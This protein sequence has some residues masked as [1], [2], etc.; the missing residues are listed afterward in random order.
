MSNTLREYRA[1][2]IGGDSASLWVTAFVGG[3]YGDSV[4]FTI[5][6]QYCA[7]AENQVKDL[8]ETLRKRLRHIRAYR[9]TSADLNIYLEPIPK[10]LTDA[11]THLPNLMEE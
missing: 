5:G 6:G 2:D 4:Q 8:I 10:H 3:K 11:I 1:I 9:A 7:L